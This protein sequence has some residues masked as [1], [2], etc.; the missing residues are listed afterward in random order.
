MTTYT[1]HTCANC[2]RSYKT[3][4]TSATGHVPGEAATCT[5]PQLCTTC[6]AVLA[7]ALGHDYQEEVIAPTCTEPGCTTHT[8]AN[9]GDTYRDDYTEAAGHQPSDWIIDREPTTDSEGSKHKECEVCGEKLEVQPIEKI[10][11][12]A[13]TDSK[14]EAIVGGYLVIVTDTDTKNPVAGATVTLH[15]DQSLSIRLPSGRLLDYAD[16]TTIQ[17]QLVKDKSP[18]ADMSISVTD[19]NNNFSSGKTDAAGQLTVPGG[20]DTTNEDGKGTVGWE[21]EDGAHWTLTVTV[22]DSETKRPIPD[23]GI[24]I[25]STGNITVTLPD[26]E[27]MDEDNNITVT[28]PDGEDMDEDNRITVTVTDHERQPQEGLSVIV[29]GDLG[30]R[31]SGETDGAGQLTVPE[32]A[33]LETHGAY[34]VGYTDGTFGPERSMRR[35]EAATIGGHH[36]CP[37]AL[38]APG[39]AHLRPHDGNLPGRARRRMVRRVCV[40]PD[41][42]WRGRGLYRRPVPWGRAH[43]PRRVHG[44]GGAVL[45]RLRGRRPGNHGGLP[46]LLGCIPRPL[47]GGLH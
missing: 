45:R 1:T 33:E 23:A 14:G 42:L 21:D 20:S 9:C 18:V 25:G 11:K 30:Q 19:R 44:Y 35:S 16:Q 8:C 40:L 6:G 34:V 12:Q 10:Y 38:P 29:K 41:P 39:R 7:E 13:T 26:G 46:G 32:V 36:L 5:T 28:L 31:E 27:D 37:P 17:V 15:E 4:Y 24:S 43:F 3:D 2:G 47:G 22:E